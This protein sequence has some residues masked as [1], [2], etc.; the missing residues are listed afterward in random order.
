MTAI[1]GAF[2][3]QKVAIAT[4]RWFLESSTARP[5]LPCEETGCAEEDQDAATL[6]GPVKRECISWL[7]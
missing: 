4:K 6:S 3:R 1:G 7:L 5:N 2:L